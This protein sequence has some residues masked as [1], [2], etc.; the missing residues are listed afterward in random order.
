MMRS[1]KEVERKEQE[2][3]E[4]EEKEE[5]KKGAGAGTGN[6]ARML[7]QPET[8][9]IL[10]QRQQW[11]KWDFLF[12]SNKQKGSSSREALAEAAAAAWRWKRRC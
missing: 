11:K 9:S 1:R 10:N 7:G 8:G 12:F 2:E 6:K 4:E 3:K 5:E